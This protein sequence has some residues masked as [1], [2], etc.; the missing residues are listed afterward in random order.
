MLSQNINSNKDIKVLVIL[1]DGNSGSASIKIKTD[2]GIEYKGFNYELL[3]KLKDNL[4]DKYN[5][6]IEFTNEIDHNYHEFINKVHLGEFDMCAGLFH[7]EEHKHE[8]INYTT[9]IIIDANSIIY[10]KNHS[11]VSEFFYTVY[12]VLK[13]IIVII[14]SGFIAGGL[15]FIGDPDR[16][17][18]SKRLKK[19]KYLFLL[20]SLVT[21][22]ASMFGEMGYLSE[23]SSLELKGIFVAIFIFMTGFIFIM[24][25]QAKITT[26]L[27]HRESELYDK[28]N[29]SHATFL[30]FK[31]DPV[32][33]KIKQYGPTIEYVENI[34]IKEMIDMHI[35]NENKYDGCLLSYIDA[36]PIIKKN[37]NLA[38]DINFG[39]EPCGFI[40]NKEKIQLLTDINGVFLKLRENLELTNLCKINFNITKHV[41]NVPVCSLI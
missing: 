25:I 33:E 23:R 20:R 36:Y 4:N 37:K 34:S 31:G 15:L 35:N 17:K 27:I 26:L 12:D 2:K 9:P 28:N 8:L 38:V 13:Y 10:V 39:N 14:I 16:A 41:N 22:I 32:V 18:H 7:Y 5:F 6:I 30:G 11:P 19:N 21:G 1:G 3:M 40:V 29:I 24:Y